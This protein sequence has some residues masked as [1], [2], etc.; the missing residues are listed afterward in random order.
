MI[1]DNLMNLELLLWA[2]KNSDYAQ[3]TEMATRH[4]ITTIRHH[5]RPDNSTFHVVDFNPENGTFIHG[6][7]WQGYSDSSCWARGQAWGVYGFTMVFRETQDQQFLNAATRLADYFIE[8]LPADGIPYWDFRAPD[9]PHSQRDASAAAIAASGLLE[10][11]RL[12]LDGDAKIRYFK[13]AECILS[14]LSSSDYLTRDK[15]NDA[16]LLHSVGNMKENSEVDV[17]L[18]FADYYFIEALMRYRSMKQ[19]H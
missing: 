19:Q 1:I 6:L 7:T 2:G 15:A 17:P 9:I 16:L 4:A 18:I 10:L 5:I 12:V 14:T 11:S 8:H 13:T 3:F